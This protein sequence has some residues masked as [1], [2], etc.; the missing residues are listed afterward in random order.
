[1]FRHNT[2]LVL[3]LAVLVALATACERTPQNIVVPD[4]SA[5]S[6]AAQ[7]TGGQTGIALSPLT[8]RL[9]DEQGELISGSTARVTLALGAN[10]TGAT[11]SGTL[12]RDAVAG[13]ATFD[14]A[15]ID[16]VGIGYTLTAS[17]AE[18]TP[19]ETAPFNVA[20]PGQHVVAIA[21]SKDASL[22]QSS[23]GELANG[24]GAGIFV[25]R[26]NQGSNY[27]R[28]GLIAFD[29]A[30]HV[31]AGAVIEQVSLEMHGVTSAD[32][33]FEDLTLQRV[34][35]DWSEGPSI[36]ADGRGAPS[37]AGDSTWLHRTYDGV[38]WSMPGGDFDTNISATTPVDDV[39]TYTWQS[40]GL[41]ADV[42]SMLDAP[43][44]N[45]GWIIIGNEVEVRTVK[46]L[47][48]RDSAADQP[49]MVVV[50]TEP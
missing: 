14:D 27:L 16:T 36:A 50:F 21:P 38:L 30:A 1:M 25:G 4:P 22:F 5:L 48:S 46:V 6:F 45:F 15:V 18:L 31:P 35:A 32:S 40:P 3:A 19:I 33:G 44:S 29:I 49:Q 2:R 34:T 20:P 26:T 8:V 42:Q 43:A 23:A 13:E 7:P 11:L 37:E 47:A 28:R 12:E 41:V 17:V 39:G 9:L 24:A 10:P